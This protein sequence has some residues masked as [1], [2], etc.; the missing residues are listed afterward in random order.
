MTPK[1]KPI[2]A[3]P[4]QPH[5]RRWR[6][7]SARSWSLFYRDHHRQDRAQLMASSALEQPQPPRRRC[8]RAAASRWRC[9][10]LGFAAVPLYR[11]FCQVTGFG[12]TTQRATKR[13]ARPARSADDDLDP[14][15]RQRR[16]AACRGA[17]SPSRRT[18][19]VAIG[20]ARHGVLHRAA[21]CRTSRSP[22]PRRFNVDARA[23]RQVF[24]QDPVL[25]L[26]R[27]DAAAGR[28][29]CACR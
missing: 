12:G 5:A 23:G 1:T 15:R 21:T 24:H 6:W 25:L 17:S 27:A 9:S 3:P 16:A 13:G 26:H 19:T 11:M 20:A 22:A 29:K 14:L 10:A 28:R 2:R 8:C 18:D 4:A 7:C